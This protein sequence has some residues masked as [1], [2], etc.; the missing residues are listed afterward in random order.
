M[1]TRGGQE[2][3]GSAEARRAADERAR[4]RDIGALRALAPFLRPYAGQLA[5]A[6]LALVLTAAL[7][8]VLPLAVGRVVD[9]FGVGLDEAQ[10]HLPRPLLSPPPSRSRRC[11]RSARGRATTSSRAWAS[12]SWP[13]SAAGCSTA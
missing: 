10:V 13:T 9:G 1:A 4:S 3:T 2:R 6:L 7:S 12:A 8:L 11:S 5:L